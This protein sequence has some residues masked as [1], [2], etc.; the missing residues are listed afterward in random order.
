MTFASPS[1]VAVAIDIGGT[2]TDV[3]LLD[4]ATGQIWRTKTPSTPEDQSIGFVEGIRKIAGLAGR[5][6]TD[7]AQLFHATT[8]ATNLILEGKGAKAAV[9][10]TSGFGHVLEIGRHDIPGGANPYTWVKPKRPV[11]PELIF[12]VGGRISKDGEELEPL[13][14]AAVRSAG[15]KIAQLGIGT[16]AVCL[17]N[18]YVSSA[19]ELRVRDILVE[20]CPGA[21]I[22]LSS[23]ILPVFREYERSMVTLLNA[24]VAPAVAGY[25]G[26]LHNR[27]DALGIKAPLL[28]MKSNGGVAGAGE[29][30]RQPVQTALSGPAAGVVGASFFGRMAGFDNIIGIDIGG[31]SAD[32]SVIRGGTPNMSV[33]SRIAD[34]P[35]TLPM[36]DVHTI[37]A[38]GGSIAEVVNGT[39]KVG[40]ASAGAQPGPVCYRRGGTRPTVTDAHVVLGHLPPYLM[41][42]EMSLDVEGAAEAI[43]REVAE[44]LGMDVTEAAR[45]ILS[46]ADNKMMGA[47]RLVSVERGLDPRDFALMPFGGAGPLH[48]GALARL[49]GVRTIV[50]PPAPG[51]LSAIGLLVSNLRSEF[52]RTLV[53]GS[54]IDPEAIAKAYAELG[55]EGSAWLDSE[56]IAGE[57]RSIGW[58]ADMRYMNQGF[59]LSVPW[60]G[61]EVNADTIAATVQAFHDRHAELYTFAQP[62]VPVEIVTLRVSATGTLPH[63]HFPRIGSGQPPEACITGKMRVAFEAGSLDCPIYDREAMGAG[64]QVAGPAIFR[65]VDTTIL[66]LPGQ[67]AT[68]DPHGCMI[69][70]DHDHG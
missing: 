62:D 25:V 19:H 13:D 29:I 18:A 7:V 44:P 2:F 46:I 6:E 27:I 20:S 23:E 47:I 22:S 10:A 14:E 24:Y 15:A 43:Q 50:I 58:S 9:L 49:L 33:E 59:E 55:T 37:G 48:G 26:N 60:Q 40:P 11:P 16:I 8:V 67:T 41:N 3:T 17:L 66:L 30:S 70:H 39:L 5:E 45:G 69:I 32:I 35:I 12:E 42:G 28:L 54:G 56:D 52:S 63:P 57:A 68:I 61:D 51:V 38:G 36:I 1:N 64:A 21:I 4:R 31:T 65:Q 34:W 53:Q